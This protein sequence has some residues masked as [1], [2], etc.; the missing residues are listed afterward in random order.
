[1]LSGTE[2]AKKLEANGWNVQ[3]VEDYVTETMDFRP[4][5][6]SVK[7]PEKHRLVTQSNQPILLD[8]AADKDDKNNHYF[9]RIEGIG[10][11]K[12]SKEI[13]TVR[14]ITEL[15]KS[16]INQANAKRAMRVIK[17]IIQ[18]PASFLAK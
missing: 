6:M 4:G 5:F 12:G 9:I 8:V 15:Q 18:D 14:I 16:K 1:M 13:D 2:I 10:A 17:T 7:K 11:S 3:N